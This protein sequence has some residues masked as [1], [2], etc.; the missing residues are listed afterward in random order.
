[1]LCNFR[2]IDCQPSVAITII[3]EPSMDIGMKEI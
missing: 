3:E 1:M 2:F